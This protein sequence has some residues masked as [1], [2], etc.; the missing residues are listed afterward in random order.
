MQVQWALSRIVGSSFRWRG[1]DVGDIVYGFPC[2]CLEDFFSRSFVVSV[3]ELPF[4][5][6]ILLG[7][8]G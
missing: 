6:H 3:Y 2:T 5:F 4:I 7:D 8:A 1:S